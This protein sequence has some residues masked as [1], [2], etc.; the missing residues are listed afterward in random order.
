MC[1][2]RNARYDD[3][4]MRYFAIMKAS[5]RGACSSSSTARHY[6]GR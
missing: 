4:N 5:Y 6:R 3:L 2:E 1:F